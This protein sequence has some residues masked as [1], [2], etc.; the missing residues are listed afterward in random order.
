MR[1]FRPMLEENPL[2]QHLISFKDGNAS[3]RRAVT[4]RFF[5]RV[6]RNVHHETE[7]VEKFIDMAY[8]L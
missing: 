6:E 3:K 1:M 5:A 8:T 2:E 7:G 4:N